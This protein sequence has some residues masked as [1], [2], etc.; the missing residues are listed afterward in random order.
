MPTCDFCIDL[1]H[2][3]CHDSACTC[4]V[5]DR[6]L[7]GVKGSRSA[8]HTKRKSLSKPST[9]KYYYRAYTKKDT[10][11]TRNQQK[12]GFRSSLTE[13]QVTQLMAMRDESVS[14]SEASRRL[15]VSRDKVRNVYR[16]GSKTQWRRPVANPMLPRIALETTSRIFEV[17]EEEL[18][19][20]SLLP[21]LVDIRHVAMYVCRSF[22]PTPSYPCIAR[23]FN[24]DHTSIISAVHRV[25][26]NE[27]LQRMAMRVKEEM[28]ADST[29]Q[30]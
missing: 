24:R 20:R 4:T 18:Q 13:E 29:W 9:K 2:I 10:V 19:S 26:Q 17:S 30:T 23:A 8:P 27:E 22:S 1:R 3:R 6:G 5:C 15:D 25:E 11:R 16:E 14:I 21:E 28:N 7:Y 12:F